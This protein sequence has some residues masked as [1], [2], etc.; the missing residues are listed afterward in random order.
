M[1]LIAD[2]GATRAR[3][4]LLDDRGRVLAPEVFRNGDFTGIEG[5]L[6]IYLGHRRASDR[7]RRAAL[8]V[9]APILSDE[10]QMINIDWR[11]SQSELKRRCG[12]NHLTVVNDFAAV[13]WGL[14]EFT[15][16]DLVQVGGGAPTPHM[17]MAVLGP[18]SGLGVAAIVPSADSWAVASGEGGHVSVSTLTAQEAAVTDLIRDEHGH[19]SVEQLVSGPGLVNIHRAL[20]TL[21]GRDVPSLTPAG[22]TELAG[23]GDPLARDALGVF[24]EVLGTTAGNLAL[25][26]GARGGLFVAGGIIPQLL[27]PFQA[28]N[29]RARFEAKGRYRSYMQTIPTHVIVDPLPAF[30]GLRKLLGY[31]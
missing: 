14:P 11:F 31:R 5:L 26:V 6:E 30:R 22:I 15:P 23:Q 19:C 17:P 1:D 16:A 28:S 9:A 3:C 10:V 8:A 4:A 29:F 20:A 18:G 24:F 27:K 7:P 21:A 13:A 25:T 12:L 2:I